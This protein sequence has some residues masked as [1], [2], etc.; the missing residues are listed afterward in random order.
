MTDDLGG[1]LELVHP[2]D[3]PDEHDVQLVEATRIGERRLRLVLDARRTYDIRAPGS[4]WEID[5]DGVA[6]SRLELG[7]WTELSVDLDHALAWDCQYRRE[8]LYLAGAVERPAA[9]AADLLEHD[10][11]LL[12]PGL[13]RRWLNAVV[14]LRSLIAGG[15][16]L[17]ACG[18]L[19]A[20]DLYQRLMSSHG[21]RCARL[22]EPDPGLPREI[23]EAV[24]AG[25]GLRTL[26]IGDSYVVAARLEA[27]RT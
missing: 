3:E 26:L 25:D 8:A 19:P 24:A 17:V 1:L 13:T 11:R 5:C 22:R 10:E 15:H 9:L 6:E 21:A 27:R 20:I 12:A 23:S 16:G 7:A 18:P 14:P 4:R 2:A